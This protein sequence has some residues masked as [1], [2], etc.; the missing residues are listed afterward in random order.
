MR[1]FEIVLSWPKRE[2][3]W[4]QCPALSINLFTFSGLYPFRNFPCF[5]SDSSFLL[6]KFFDT[7]HS[8]C[9]CLILV[10]KTSRR[11]TRLL[12]ELGRRVC[13]HIFHHRQ[14]HSSGGF[15]VG[16]RVVVVKLMADVRRQGG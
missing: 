13:A 5:P 10:T 2:K 3:L 1:R 12:Q 9:W 8:R 4:A 11:H 6:I 14:Q 16:L 7:W 15:G